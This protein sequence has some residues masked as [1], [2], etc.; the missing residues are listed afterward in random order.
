MIRK[1]DIAK[2]YNSRAVTRVNRD[3]VWH[4][5]TCNPDRKYARLLVCV[6]WDE[7]DI[8]EGEEPNAW[9]QYK[10]SY[11]VWTWRNEPPFHGWQLEDGSMLRENGDLL[12][13]MRS[14][15]WLYLTGYDRDGVECDVLF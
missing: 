8:N 9:T 5:H 13:R 10:S 7:L 11:H 2:D 15:S 1:D 14:F 3:I 4:P 12:R 6:I